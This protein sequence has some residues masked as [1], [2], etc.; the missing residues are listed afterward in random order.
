MISFQ[1]ITSWSKIWRVTRGCQ[2]WR[3]TTRVLCHSLQDASRTLMTCSSTATLKPRRKNRRWSST[4]L[5]TPSWPI[6]ATTSNNSSLPFT[7]PIQCLTSN[8]TCTNNNNNS[9][10]NTSRSRSSPSKWLS[11]SNNS[12]SSNLSLCIQKSTTLPSPR[13][14]T[15]ST[16]SKKWMASRSTA[17]STTLKT[18]DSTRLSKNR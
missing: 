13:I 6:V 12:V 15:W 8:T 1:P 10:N 9:N 17:V 16:W 14:C 11:L 18:R 7:S 4:L 3:T 2:P 5:P